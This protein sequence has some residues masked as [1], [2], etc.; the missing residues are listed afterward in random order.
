MTSTSSRLATRP[1]PQSDLACLPRLA[2][3]KHLLKAEMYLSSAEDG[4]P[5]EWGEGTVS[6]AGA[7]TLGAEGGSGLSALVARQGREI[8]TLTDSLASS[9]AIG[10]AIGLIMER[11]K[12]GSDRAFE[13]L[14]RLSQNH[15]IKLRVV[16]LGIITTAEEDARSQ[17]A[18]RTI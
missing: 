4:A 13:F 8:E 15:N 3:Q 2:T 10:Q 17:S 6:N 7:A 16:A 11:Y 14:V 12:I 18:R 9:R 1:V 5:D